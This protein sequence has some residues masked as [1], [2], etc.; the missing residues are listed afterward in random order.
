MSINS[1]DLLQIIEKT[2]ENTFTDEKISEQAERAAAKV[3]SKGIE[4]SN[5][6]TEGLKQGMK[7]ASE[8]IQVCVKVSGMFIGLLEGEENE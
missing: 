1:R 2:I 8:V 7:A 6:Y 4:V 5:D 3:N